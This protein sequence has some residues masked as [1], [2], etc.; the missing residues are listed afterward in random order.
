MFFK[1]GAKKGGAQWLAVF[2]GN[3]GDKYE[4]TRHNMGFLAADVFAKEHDIKVNKSK[5]DSLYA[6]TE[7]GD[8]KVCILKPMTYMNLSGRAV[9]AAADFYKI[10]PENIIVV[11]DDMNIPA[12]R[13]RIRTG[14]SAGG[15]NG[16]KDII[17]HMHTDAIPRI[18]VGIGRPRHEGDDVID[19]VI[20]RITDAELKELMPSIERAA[21]A[22]EEIILKG[23][24]RAMDTFNRAQ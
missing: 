15:H 24:Q 19:W 22:V 7:V 23:P 5:F 16:M 21:K 2:L 20:N 13:L 9:R 17:E 8:S 6:L 4:R 11:L 10:K 14:G 3:P 18:R 12:G 1:S